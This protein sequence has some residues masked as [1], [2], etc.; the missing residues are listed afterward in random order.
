MLISVI[1]LIEAGGEGRLLRGVQEHA[2]IDLQRRVRASLLE[3]GRDEITGVVREGSNLCVELEA[4][5][6]RGLRRSDLRPGR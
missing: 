1:G 4:I 6:W 5:P 2:E 3:Q